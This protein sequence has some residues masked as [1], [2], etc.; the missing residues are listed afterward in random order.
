MRW[1]V[2]CSQPLSQSEA[3]DCG[4][5]GFLWV[6]GYLGGHTPK[7]WEA[8]D[9]RACWREDLDMLPIWVMQLGA[10]DPGRSQGVEDGN[11]ALARM[12]EMHLTSV[13]ALDVENGLKPEQYLRGFCDAVHAGSCAVVLYGTNETLWALDG[14]ADFS[15]LAHWGPVSVATCPFPAAIWQFQSSVRFDFNVAYED[16]IFAGYVADELM[17]VTGQRST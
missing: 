14:I 4:S 11:A 17:P 1:G 6:G 3:A 8:E 9:W 5:N 10:D 7:Q 12:Q 13:L 2:D 16:F 15:W